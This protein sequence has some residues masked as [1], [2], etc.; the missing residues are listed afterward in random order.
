MANPIKWIREQ[1]LA[2]QL[3]LP[4]RTVRAMRWSGRGPS[5]YRL[6]KRILYRPED[7]EQFLSKARVDITEFTE[8][9]VT[10]KI[11]HDRPFDMEGLAPTLHV[12]RWWRARSKSVLRLLETSFKISYRRVPSEAGRRP[13][14]TMPTR[15]PK[16]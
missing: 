6:G 5:F 10:W 13:T 11:S 2:L 15:W 14:F 1:D 16:S 8:G 3:G 12:R 7:V 4:L 9:P